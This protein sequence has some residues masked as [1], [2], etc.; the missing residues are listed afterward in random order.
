MFKGRRVA[1]LETR[2]S[3]EAASLVQRLGGSPYRVPAVHELL[4]PE[5]IGRFIERLTAGDLAV[6]VFLTG[7]GVSALLHEATRLGCLES[8]LSALRRTIVACRGPK[9][10]SVLTQHSVPV[11]IAAAEPHT[12]RELMEALQAID[13]AGKAV[14]LVRYGEPNERLASALTSRG[15]RLEE[16]ALYEWR[17]PDDLEPLRTLVGD[18]VSGS[19]DA[20]AFTNEIQVRHLFRVAGDCGAAANLVNALNG[21][22]VVGAI[23]PICAAALHGLGVTPDV[24]PAK[25]QMGSLI[26][27]LAEY[28][29]L[30]EGLA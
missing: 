1:L 25:P 11:H 6:V 30:T 18:L 21:D 26:T 20:I 27:A 7:A 2:M 28:F 22:I 16:V 23:G 8:T 5:Q 3:D 19:L 9:P 4:H 29:D 10:I 13:L 12:T 17:L 24:I 14:A 15:A